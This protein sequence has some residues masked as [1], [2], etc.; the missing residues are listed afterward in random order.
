MD[1]GFYTW[2]EFKKDILDRAPSVI[3]KDMGDVEL[4]SG[5][6][7]SEIARAFERVSAAIDKKD[8]QSSSKQVPKE[9]VAD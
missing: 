9:A 6:L 5:L 1:S 3:E 4:E 7:S 2:A 8:F